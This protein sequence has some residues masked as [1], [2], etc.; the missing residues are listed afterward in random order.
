MTLEKKIKCDYCNKQINEEEELVQV[1]K[2]GEVKYYCSSE[3]YSKDRNYF[4]YIGRF[5]GKEND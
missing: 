2:D 1:R 4:C 5:R 3:C